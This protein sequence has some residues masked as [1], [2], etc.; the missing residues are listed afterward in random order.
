MKEAVRPNEN[1]QKFWENHIKNSNF[2][3]TGTHGNEQSTTLRLNDLVTHGS[4]LL[5]IGVGRGFCTQYWYNFG[6]KVS[7]LDITMEAVNKVTSYIEDYYLDETIESLPKN[8]FDFITSL[9]V[10]QHM[11]FE[12]LNRHMKHVIDS[13]TPTGLF[14]FQFAYSLNGKLNNE[15]LE[16][17]QIGESTRTLE[18]MISIIISN[19]GHMV[20]MFDAGIYPDFNMGWKIL[21]IKKEIIND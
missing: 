3:L 11:N 16:T 19:G 10:I 2:F 12:T 5:N 21:H 6:C 7:V 20:S 17:C 14:A 1:I 15:S 13:L 9:L 4:T 18:E 8:K